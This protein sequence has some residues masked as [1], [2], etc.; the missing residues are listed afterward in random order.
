MNKTSGAFLESWPMPINFHEVISF[1]SLKECFVTK[2]QN[3][4]SRTQ[5]STHGKVKPTS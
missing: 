3:E 5:K 2:K 4:T 1:K